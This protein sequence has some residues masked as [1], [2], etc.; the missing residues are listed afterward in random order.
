[1]STTTRAPSS[2]SSC[3]ASIYEMPVR[4]AACATF[5]KGNYSDVMQ[6]CCHSAPVRTYD[7]DC[8]IYC[9]AVDQ[10]IGDL[11]RCMFS[12]G[13]AYD[14]GF[15]N[16]GNTSAMATFSPKATNTRA[17]S[18]SISTSTSTGSSTSSMGTSGANVL[19]QPVSRSGLG[20]LGLVFCSVLLGVF[21]LT[22]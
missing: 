14:E 8:A 1:M 13:I 11:T 6:H 12:H 3:T 9:L 22:G 21:S 7:N 4:D 19:V 20:V 17:S 5:A 15:C 18:A 10:T 2:A 16:K